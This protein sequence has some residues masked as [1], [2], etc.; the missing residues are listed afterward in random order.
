MGI[1][2]RSGPWDADRI[3]EFLSSAV[4]PIRIAS[5][6][7]Q[8]PMVQSLWF[9]Y[10]DAALW[11]CTQRDSLLAKRLR[12]DDLVG[13][14]VSGDQPPY[15]GVRGRGRAELVD[16]AAASLLPQLIERYLGEEGS[17][18]PLARWLLGR[19][20]SETAIRI[21]SITATSWDYSGRM[22]S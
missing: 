19:L 16:D 11:C 5:S 10:A 4:I 13:F 1:A 18:A 6:G 8:G 9:A 21:H 2:V 3:A 20:D 7:R 22:G 14:E 12:R 15:R 17:Q